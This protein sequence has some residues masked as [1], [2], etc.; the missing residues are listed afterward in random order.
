M[1]YER[2]NVETVRKEARE[3]GISE[4]DIALI[5]PDNETEYTIGEKIEV[6]NESKCVSVLWMERGDDG[7]VSVAR[8]V[9]ACVYEPLH[10]LSVTRDG[11]GVSGL[12]SYPIVNMIWEEK[13]GSARGQSQV[14]ALIPNQIEHNRT[15]AR[16]SVAVKLC[17][18][19]RLVYASG[20]IEN[21]ESLDVAGAKIEVR[22]EID[23]AI[24]S[25]VGYISPAGMS[26]DAKALS[27]DLVTGTKDLE[28]ASDAAV[29]QV[30]PEKASGAAIAAVRDQAALPLN[31]QVAAYRQFVEDIA[32]LWYDLWAAYKPNGFIVDYEEGGERLEASV[33]AEDLEALKV[34][35]RVDVSPDNPWTKYAEQQELSNL[36]AKKGISLEEYLEVSPPNSPLPVA[37]L[38]RILA[39]RPPPAPQ[40]MPQG[41]QG[42]PEGLPAV[43]QGLPASDEEY[44]AMTEG[45][46]G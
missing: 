39:K 35:V 46:Y 37:K 2:R 19:P 22:G 18:Y 8:S 32:L 5:M 25:I 24:N 11:E 20:M 40:G 6:K 1:I 33:T 34:S 12:K 30:N 17:A 27:E 4:D 9:R 41:M 7:I 10:P 13:P 3:N 28:G 36:Y 42:A 21:K 29:G 26:P 44:M 45:G 23:K 15:L 31:E 43:P 38:K 14:A 16:R